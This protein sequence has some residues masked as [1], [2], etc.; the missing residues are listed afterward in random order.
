MTQY[1]IT[2]ENFVTPGDTG[3]PDA[4]LS[5]EDQA[6]IAAV[7]SQT[8]LDKFLKSRIAERVAQTTEHKNTI[9]INVENNDGN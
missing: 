1:R 6:V 3:E 8:T 5:L 7:A 4:V 9:T 2:S